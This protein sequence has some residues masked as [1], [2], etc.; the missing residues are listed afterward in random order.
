[1]GAEAKDDVVPKTDEPIELG[2]PA[3]DAKGA[4]EPEAEKHVDAAEP[5]EHQPAGRH[6]PYARDQAER[7]SPTYQSWNSPS[8]GPTRKKKKGMK[9]I[10]S[11]KPQARTGQPSSV[12]ENQESPHTTGT[13]TLN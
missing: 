12:A 6:Y 5:I 7:G 8:V 11:S 2:P 13:R 9:S 1:A 4:V 3:T 10:E